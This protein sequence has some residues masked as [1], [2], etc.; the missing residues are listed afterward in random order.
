M[1]L[2]TLDF[3]KHMDSR[4]LPFLDKRNITTEVI[5]LDDNDA[6]YWINAV[7]ENWDGNIPV[8]KFI[9]GD[10]S[11]FH[12]SSLTYEELNSILSTFSY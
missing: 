6:N 3:P 9:Q 11:K 7:N 2:V 4:L 5:L 10:K 1:I 12:Y 8:T